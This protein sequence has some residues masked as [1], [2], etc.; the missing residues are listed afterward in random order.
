M[1][2]SSFTR[3]EEGNVIRFYTPNPLKG[4]TNI[5]YYTDNVSGPF[6]KKEFRWSFNS[7]YWSSWE[8]LNQGNLSGINIGSNTYLFLEIRYISAG[9]T[10]TSFV[11]NYEGPAQTEY[12]GQSC[13]PDSTYVAPDQ[14]V[15]DSYTP[16]APVT[17]S[18]PV[19]AETLCGKSCDYYL[20]R[21]NHKGEQPISTI[22]DLQ[23]ILN[24]LSA[25]IQNSITGA[26]NVSGDGI[27]VYYDKSG[28]DLIFSRIN[29][30][31]GIE[32]NS[33]G[34]V[35]TLAIDASLVTKDPSVNELYQLY[36]G[37]EQDL[38]DISIYI[39][40]KFFE[41]D[42]SINDLY[43]KLHELDA[44]AIQDI[45]NVGGG[46]GEIFKQIS[47]N[48]AELRTIA[49]GNANVVVETVG[50]QVRISLDASV[51]GAPVWSDPDPVSAD[52]GGIIGGY[53]VSVG[54]NSIEILEKILYE[55]FPPNID[56]NVVPNIS[57]ATGYYQKWVQAPEVS[58]YGTFNNDDF[59]KAEIY[60]ASLYIN[61]VGDAGFPPFSYPDVS[62]G[63]FY[64]NDTSPPYGA[65]WD[66]VVYNVKIYNKVNGNEM[67]P[68]DASGAVRFAEPYFYGVVPNTVSASNIT[69]T[70]IL[71]LN[72]L[73]V[74]KQTNQIDYDVSANYVKIKFVYAYPDSHGKLSTI[75]DVKNDFNVTSSF[76]QTTLSVDG[77]LAT[78]W[79]SSVLYRV[80]I[81][82]HWISF[83]PDV[84]IFKIIFN[85]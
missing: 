71:A 51:S 49:S 69:E 53:E 57:S 17:P 72:Q 35:I 54:A 76:D 37:L 16:G 70:D 14:T 67:P 8:T 36:Y 42:S 80:Y 82:D 61:G 23:L 74:P 79:V 18:G 31:Y 68:A 7:D 73:V 22:T 15:E 5:K 81:K 85:I 59:V 48:T 78:P 33:S 44:S 26:Q 46:P 56:L 83:T 4:V 47:G 41:I 40:G 6:Q 65:G 43:L 60:D 45:S 11:L 27:G 19:N 21:P 12:T 66:D 32:L 55:Y 30:E 50:D 13:P 77:P 9:G 34:G 3:S 20:W 58:I 29:G 52:V 10:V 24:N 64:W 1:Q 2:F 28:Q 39:D 75:F 25:G 84:S 38:Y 62:D 63:D